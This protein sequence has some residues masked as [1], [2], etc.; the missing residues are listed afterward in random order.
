MTVRTSRS[1]ALKRLLLE[2][3]QQRPGLLQIGGVKAL[4][5]PAVDAVPAGP[6]LRCLP[7][8]C[9]RRLRLT[10]AR[11]SQDLACWRRAMVQ[12]L[13]EAGFRLGRIRGGLPQQEFALES[14]RL[15]QHV[16][17]PAG[18]ERCQGLRQQAQ[19]LVNLARLPR[20]LGQQD[21]TERPRQQLPCG[22]DGRQTLAHLRQA[23][24]ALALHG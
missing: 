7:C 15:C 23:R 8:C 6:G 16:A 21:Q 3:L 2:F 1:T 11:S 20:R 9:H 5:E 19:P 24:L 12:G 17:P 13:L 14:I 4:G 10:A 22:Q 18:L